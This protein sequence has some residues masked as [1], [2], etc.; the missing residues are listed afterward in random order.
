MK[1]PPLA[2]VPIS[3]L[4]A[5]C[6]TPEAADY[7]SVASPLTSCA[8]SAI[9]AAVAAGGDVVVDCGPAPVTVAVPSTTVSRPTRLRPAVP[10]SITLVHSGTL[11]SVT[12]G[13]P[14]EIQNIAF[15]GSSQ[16]SFAVHMV[17]GSAVLT[18]DTFRGYPSF[19]VSVH[20]GSR[21]TVDGCLFADN[22]IGSNSFF[23]A[24]IYN[25]G[26]FADIRGSTF[27]NNRSVGTGGAITSLN[28][29]LSVTGS[30]FVNNVASSGG[31]IGLS[32]FAT[33]TIA[34]TTFVNNQAT[35]QSGAIDARGPGTTLVTN[36][37]FA[38]NISPKGTMNGALQVTASILQERF[39]PA[40]AVCQLAGSSNLQW[41]PST[42]SC[43]P[44]FRYGDPRLAPLA[45]NGGLTQTMALL[46]GS[47]AIDT[48]T[49][50]CPQTDQRGV[51]RPRDG[52]ASGSAI[53][54]LGAY[55][56]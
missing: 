51:A 27:A 29:T 34:N 17:S 40:G 56:R 43:G 16:S 6:G 14:F 53:C 12:S 18:G 23:A 1:R 52:D 2:L 46:F 55:E 24:A 4:L 13:A 44:G 39:S 30:T 8:G 5:A 41:P 31:A 50:A 25:E 38:D 3:L 15:Q 35:G 32:A 10:G 7:E 26:S 19:M 21:L 42:P 22:G 37:T 33:Q 9:S 54:D 28:G 49:V 20:R 11:F 47:A 36:C 45:S 48:A